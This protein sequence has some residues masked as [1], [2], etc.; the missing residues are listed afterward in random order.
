MSTPGLNKPGGAFPIGESVGHNEKEWGSKMKKTA[1]QKKKP[2]NGGKWAP[3]KE[4]G[5]KEK[6][7]R[8]GDF[9]FHRKSESGATPHHRK[10]RL[11]KGLSETSK[12][13]KWGPGGPGEG[14]VDKAKG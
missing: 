5:T 13:E 1:C 6:S 12:K 3:A 11:R 9:R 14:G 10:C 2:K 8:E 7:T 4:N